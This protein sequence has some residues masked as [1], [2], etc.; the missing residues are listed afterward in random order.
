[1]KRMFGR[2]ASAALHIDARARAMQVR[3]AFMGWLGGFDF[4]S[5]IGDA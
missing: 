2:G 3:R 5:M 4:R 1:M